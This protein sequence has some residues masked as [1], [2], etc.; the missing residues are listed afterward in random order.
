MF[1]QN[2]VCSFPYRWLQPESYLDPKQCDV[3]YNKDE[4]KCSWPANLIVQTKDQYGQ[5]VHV[6]NLKVTFV[7][8]ER[9]LSWK[10][11]NDYIIWLSFYIFEIGHFH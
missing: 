6:P 8:A 10:S 4:L 11:H 3:V 2:V 7:K 5:I 1:S 9:D